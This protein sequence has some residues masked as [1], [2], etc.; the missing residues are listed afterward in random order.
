VLSGVRSPKS[1]VSWLR[2][3]DP[4]IVSSFPHTKA[5]KRS[6]LTQYLFSDASDQLIEKL[7][8][9]S[10]ELQPHEESAALLV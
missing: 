1:Y 5:L 4:Y 8:N 9:V 10:I 6:R 2:D 3:S 7:L